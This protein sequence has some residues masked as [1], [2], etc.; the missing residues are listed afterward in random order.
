M[1]TVNLV[2]SVNCVRE[3][4]RGNVWGCW[5]CHTDAEGKPHWGFTTTAPNRLPVRNPRFRNRVESAFGL[6]WNLAITHPEVLSDPRGSSRPPRSAAS[7]LREQA[8]KRRWSA[9]RAARRQAERAATEQPMLF[10]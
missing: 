6:F 2:S 10:A 5:S 3:S 9:A 1:Q 4:E 7:A 8:R